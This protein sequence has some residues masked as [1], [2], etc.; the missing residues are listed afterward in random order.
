MV[1]VLFLLC[2]SAFY[3]TTKPIEIEMKLFKLR[4]MAFSYN[5]HVGWGGE[6]GSVKDA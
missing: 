6:G 1:F 5:G 3:T 2:G 4:T